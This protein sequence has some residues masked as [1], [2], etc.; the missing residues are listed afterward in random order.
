MDGANVPIESESMMAS[1]S[2]RNHTISNATDIE[3]MSESRVSNATDLNDIV[4][5]DSRPDVPMRTD[6][7]VV[8]KLSVA[9]GLGMTQPSAV[10]DARRSAPYQ[11]QSPNRSEF[12]FRTP[13]RSN[14]IMVDQIADQDLVLRVRSSPTRLLIL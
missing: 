14:P 7:P 4:I 2:S 1:S 12:H 6:R 9:K 10:R 3:S 13:P 8:P 11:S 5:A